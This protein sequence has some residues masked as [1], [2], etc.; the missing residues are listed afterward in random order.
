[1]L[2]PVLN[3]STSTNEHQDPFTQV[4]EDTNQR[5]L[6]QYSYQIPNDT[7]PTKTAAAGLKW[8][9]SS[10]SSGVP[11]PQIDRIM[12]F[13]NLDPNGSGVNA[14]LPTGV[15]ADQ[16]FRWTGGS[17]A[18]VR[19]GQYLVVGPRK[20]TYLGSKVQSGSPHHMPSNHRFE[21]NDQWNWLHIWNQNNEPAMWA[22]PNKNSTKPKPTATVPP[23][24]IAN[25]TPIDAKFD[26]AFADRVRECVCMTAGMPVP[27]TW[28][29][30]KSDPD[31]KITH[32]G[33]NVSEPTRDNYYDEPLYILNSNDS[34]DPS[35]PENNAVSFKTL[36]KDAYIDWSSGNGSGSSRPP[37]DKTKYLGKNNWDDPAN[38][39]DYP[40]IKTQRN[41]TAAALQ[42]LADPQRPYHQIYNPY[43]TVDW[44]SIDLTVFSGEETLG[45]DKPIY[46]A[47]RHKTGAMLQPSQAFQPANSGANSPL[48]GNTFYS[49]HSEL[50]T[51][52]STKATP[53]TPV[54][55]SYELQS[56]YYASTSGGAVAQPRSG[57]AQFSTFGYLNPRFVIRGTGAAQMPPVTGMDDY[58]FDWYFLGAP[59]PNP[60]AVQQSPTGDVVLKAPLAPYHAN[61]DFVSQYELTSVPL[62][63]PGQFFQD[64]S[65]QPYVPSSSPVPV[66]N[67]VL[68]FEDLYLPAVTPP[69]KA[70]VGQERSSALL[71]EC[72]DVPSPWVDSWKVVD[73]QS[74]RGYPLGSATPQQVS[75]TMLFENYRAPYNAIPTFREPGKVNLNTAT[76]PLVFRGLMWNMMTPIS[77]R[78]LT[79]STT[80]FES[81]LRLERQGFTA[82][83]SGITDANPHLHQDSPT[84]FGRLFTSALTPDKFPDAAQMS[85]RSSDVGLLRRR[86]L[87][88]GMRLFDVAE[89]G[90]FPDSTVN[91]KPANWQY[92]T[93][94]PLNS[95]IYNYP[96]SRMANLTTDRSNVFA[97]R[98]TI[99]YFEYDPTP[100]P[101]NGFVP[102]LGA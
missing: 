93:S 24:K 32:I 52:A 5:K 40:E 7:D 97:I 77:D 101:S 60:W 25:N 17:N 44:M 57:T 67:Y 81:S 30:S 36:G 3:P 37:F 99:G 56:E 53:T 35:D 10:A 76:E 20:T 84:E 45:P 8:Q 73:P 83:S 16:V 58:K 42:R 23:P 50:N 96:V 15:T 39:K 1:F 33:L 94:I 74:V 29:N 71:L 64:F 48:A 65:V 6:F 41:W 63:A 28:P 18:R 92:N 90:V 31:F 54:R 87:F 88:N 66:F 14:G 72:V 70:A 85:S 34:T 102:G 27:D 38:T 13:A 78:T 12:W 79:T 43:I 26:A 19:G 49:Y 82:G 91:L 51:V 100:N 21:F 95:F 89:K 22:Q 11:D 61:R 98:M 55:F 47:S 86:P 46:L 68:D 80:P 59:G 75:Q 69:A 62:S 4:Y 9:V 2:K